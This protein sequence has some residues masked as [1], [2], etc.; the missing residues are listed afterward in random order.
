MKFE[1]N[2]QIVFHNKL[3]TQENLNRMEN[4]ILDVVK[5]QNNSDVVA[6]AM[7]RSP[8]LLVTITAFLKRGIPFLP[9]DCSFPEERIEYMLNRANV[10]TI[11]SDSLR[12]I[13]G[14][15]T[16]YVTWDEET[17]LAYD[18]IVPNESEALSDEALA[19]IMYTSGTTG[20]PKGVEV[21]RKG[22]KNALDGIMDAVIFEPDCRIACLANM[23][24]DIF[25]LES[26]MALDEGMTVILADENERNNPRLIQKLVINNRVNAL[27]CTP[28]TIRMI[29]MTDRDLSFLKDIKTM[30]LG[31]EALPKSML[32]TLQ[33]TVSGHIYNL[34]GP[35]ETTIWAT[36][37]DL[38]HESEINIGEAINN[39]QVFIVN[40][41]MELVQDGIEGEII[42][43]G[44]GVSRGYLGE[45]EKTEKVFVNFNNAGENIRVYRTGDFGYRDKNG[46]L[47][48]IGRRDNQV[49]ILGHRIELGDI[50]YNISR[51]SDIDTNVV[52]AVDSLEE[53]SRLI[54]FYISKQ[55]L[56]ETK[57]RAEAAKYLPEYMIPG[58]WIRVPKLLYT[59]SGKISR[60][61]MLN[62]YYKTVAP[63]DSENTSK[64]ATEESDNRSDI[65]KQIAECFDTD[66]EVTLET[67]LD[68]LGMNSL[69]YVSCLVKIEELF[70]FEFDDEMLALSYF[71][72][73]GNL[74]DTIEAN[75]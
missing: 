7:N 12:T 72:T 19:Y 32:A 44:I 52:A 14:M 13:C 23:T 58:S 73:F 1:I 25:F 20:M 54:C 22:L 48:C 18:S 55:E 49:K 39:V 36:V 61:D 2:G 74:V 37:S 75:R 15:D 17:I 51:I 29:E 66:I 38:T 64:S 11:I 67:A 42:I 40:D 60:K 41:D 21:L 26:V 59:S 5:N 3:Y 56:Q 33:K 27:Q 47:F 34:Y 24:F 53:G 30:M 46:V 65:L 68:S 10:K 28:S 63:S 57:L 9:I 69:V 71:E 8:L 4:Y 31:G 50:E 43:S 35:T 16:L 62:E 6:I 45:P 70:D